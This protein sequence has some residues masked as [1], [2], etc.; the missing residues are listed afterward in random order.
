[1]NTLKNLISGVPDRYVEELNFFLFE[2]P[3]DY[4]KIKSEIKISDSSLKSYALILKDKIN[5]VEKEKQKPLL[6]TINSILENVSHLD[7]YSQISIKSFERTG[8]C[9]LRRDGYVYESAY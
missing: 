2:K 9:D 6:N 7:F 4:N 3:S 8:M 5:L 1:M